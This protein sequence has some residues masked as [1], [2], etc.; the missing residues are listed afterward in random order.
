MKIVG[1]CSLYEPLQFLENR[2]RNLNQCDLKN[3]EIFFA[4]CSSQQTWE[5]VKKIIESNCKFTYRLHHYQERTTLYYTWGWIVSQ[6]LPTT[7]YYCNTNV[8][9]I[10]DPSYH[11][12]MSKF[13][14]EHPNKLIVACPW[15]VTNTKGEIWPPVHQNATGPDI[16]KTMGHF[17]MWRADIH[18]QGITF[19]PKMVAIGD[20]YFWSEIK[21]KYGVDV[22]AIHPET[23][24]CY[25]N[26]ENN[27][28][29]KAKGP[30]GQNGEAYDRSIGGN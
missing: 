22:F 10:Q 26:H 1:M 28:Y 16:N 6:T 15:L 12:K 7:T 27:L 17:P 20:S 14:D 3:A 30:K 19:N 21:K 25:L 13:L 8:D 18:K 9:D 4:D 23:L 11:E 5:Q 2:I 29:Y 24:S